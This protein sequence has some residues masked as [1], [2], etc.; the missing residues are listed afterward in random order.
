MKIVGPHG[1]EISSI[2]DW[3]KLHPKVHWKEGR[4]AHSIAD[5]ILDRHG[6]VHLETRLSEVLGQEVTICLISPER[7]VRFDGYRGR[8]RKHDLAIHAVAA[9]GEKVF[10][11][12]EAKVD[13]TF[14]PLMLDRYEDAKKELVK[15]T[16][17]KAVDRV[18]N[19]PAW[20]SL[21]LELSS[22]L[23]VRYQLL[24]GAAGTVGAR[25]ANGEPYDLY[26]FYMLVFKT[27]L[28][29]DQVGEEN[30]QDY[31]RFISRVSGL[32][33]E[34]PD[35]VSH[36][37]TVGSKPLTCIYEHIEYPPAVVD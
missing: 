28:Y 37:L 4:S 15:N 9:G 19:L 17:S 16:R 5:F 32:D 36:L 14:G 12:L 24:H 33:I 6:A 10:V 2:E 18:R 21:E 26:V 3:A 35:V 11:G 8:G 23:D 25:R 34:Q 1:N 13:E 7:E 27:S 30:H 22:M 20:F 31:L 29:D